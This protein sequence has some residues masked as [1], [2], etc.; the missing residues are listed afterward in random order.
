[1]NGREKLLQMMA[2]KEVLE[3]EADAIASELNSPGP[4]NEAPVG[5]KGLLV[6]SMG[7]PRSDIDLYNVRNKR[8]RL[9]VINTDHK[10]LM[11]EIEKALHEF[12][13]DN[14]QNLSTS[15][16]V[17]SEIPTNVDRM[18]PT[19]LPHLSLFTKHFAIIDE[20]LTGSPSCDAG[21]L[22]GDELI[23]F[24]YVNYRTTDAI[25]AVPTVVRENVNGCISVTIR[26]LGN[27]INLE[28]YPKVW[29]GRGL[30]GCHL[31]PVTQM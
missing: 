10:A 7:F 20:I 4:N 27:I 3:I 26:R 21:L 18:D 29:A 9:A 25:N 11:K 24:G 31:S 30:L 28:L 15:Q 23:A 22:N 13:S 2:Q 1:M 5:I 6:D 16:S 12:Q 17:E 14:F 19:G 8:Q